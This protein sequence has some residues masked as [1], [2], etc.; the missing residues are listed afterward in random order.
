MRRSVWIVIAV[1]LLFIGL[2]FAY[3][4]VPSGKPIEKPAAPRNSH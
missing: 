4:L 3:A 1:V 2:I